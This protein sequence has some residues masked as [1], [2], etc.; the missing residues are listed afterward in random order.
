MDPRIASAINFSPESDRAER[1]EEEGEESSPKGRGIFVSSSNIVGK[2][3]R[4]RN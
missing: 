3:Q 1:E 2:R 4:Q